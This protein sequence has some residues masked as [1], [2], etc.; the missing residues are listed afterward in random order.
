MLAVVRCSCSRLEQLEQLMEQL[1]PLVVLME[2]QMAQST[3]WLIMVVTSNM[4]VTWLE[5]TTPKQVLVVLDVTPRQV[6]SM[7]VMVVFTPK[8]VSLVV[9]CKQLV[10]ITVPVVD[11]LVSGKIMVAR[12][13]KLQAV[14]ARLPRL[15]VVAISTTTTTV[16]IGAVE[17]AVAEAEV[18]EAPLY[19]T[20]VAGQDISL[21]GVQM[22]G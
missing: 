18:Q 19:V 9:V 1:V 12:L 6:L 3:T 16:A 17:A 7:V 5:V 14:V 13:A 15:V 21:Q 8:Q 4:V 11:N 20:D 10:A 2:Q 22:L